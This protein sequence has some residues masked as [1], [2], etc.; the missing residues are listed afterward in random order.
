MKQEGLL[1]SVESLYNQ[2]VAGA[3]KKIM[4]DDSHIL[5][6]VFENSAMSRTGHMRLP[7][8]ATNRHPSSFVVRAMKHFNANV[9]KR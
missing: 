4:T 5:H 7:F 9:H 8:A 2:E 3:L 1:Q 6:K